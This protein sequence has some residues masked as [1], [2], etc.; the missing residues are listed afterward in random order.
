MFSPPQTSLSLS[1][2]C[3][4]VESL[5]RSLN[6]L[7]ETLHHSLYSY[8]TVS[9]DRYLSFTFFLPPLALMWVGPALDVSSFI[10]VSLCTLCLCLYACVCVCVRVCVV[11]VCGVC[12]WCVCVCVC[13][14]CVRVCVVCA[15]VC[16]VC[17][18][19]WCVW[20]VCM[21]VCVCV[22]HYGS[23]Y[24]SL[25]RC[26]RALSSGLW[27]VTPASYNTEEDGH[28]YAISNSH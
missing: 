8:L 11:C 23:S 12:V 18:C 15:C 19:V 3:R 28:K 20:C 26:C 13:V 2:T 27:A 25:D 24:S 22:L 4:V 14:W 1:L 16:G 17:A 10:C 21:C 6:N 5:I 9:S 7:L